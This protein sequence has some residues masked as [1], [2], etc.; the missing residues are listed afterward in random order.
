MICLRKQDKEQ[1]N[2]HFYL[3]I[4][5]VILIMNNHSPTHG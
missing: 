3:N 1:S 4:E 2:E 5:K